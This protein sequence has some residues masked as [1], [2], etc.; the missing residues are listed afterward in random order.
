MYRARA[1]QRAMNGNVEDGF[2]WN[3]A[4]SAL[5]GFPLLAFTSRI[6]LDVWRDSK[7][8]H[9]HEWLAL[10][11]YTID[12]LTHLTI[13]FAY[14]VLALTST[15]EKTDSFMGWLWR[16]YSRADARWSVRD[17]NVISIEILTVCLGVLCLLQ[18]GAVLCRTK[19]RH[20]LQIIICTAEL[21][22]GWMTFCPEWVEGSPNLSG[23]DPVL[24]WI[25]LVFMNGL[26]VVIPALLLWDSFVRLSDVAERQEPRLS[27]TLPVAAKKENFYLRSF[28]PSRTMWVLGG[29][30]IALYGVLVPLVLS[31]RIPPG[32]DFAPQK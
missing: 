7:P 8:L 24:F 6:T 9:F 23:K 3:W 32:F 20:P 26:W 13:E 29:L 30:T 18:V 31:T 27:E 11:W 19:W 5:I 2:E 12:A 17:P 25:Y 22:G 1:I 16:E 14:V 15:A 21:Y 28:V 10:S 4:N